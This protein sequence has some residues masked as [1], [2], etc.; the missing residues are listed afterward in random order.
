M[1]GYIECKRNKW[2]WKRKEVVDVFRKGKFKL[3]VLT[4]TKL[5]C[6]Q[7]MERA[8]EDVAILL[9]HVWHSAVI[10]FGCVS[11]RFLWIKF[12]FSGVKICVVV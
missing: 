9:N 4:E 11:S 2:D 6:V 10:D 1:T 8:R 3:L 7:E 5:K 12:K